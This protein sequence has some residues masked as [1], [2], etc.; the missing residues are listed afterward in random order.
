MRF[1]PGGGAKG[2]E[3]AQYRRQL[4]RFIECA[5]NTVA[6]GRVGDV[7]EPPFAHLHGVAAVLADDAFAIFVRA[8]V[9]LEYRR[10]KER[11]EKLVVPFVTRSHPKLVSEPKRVNGREPESTG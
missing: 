10:V 5:Q 6:R 7:Y 3:G 9:L 1:G 4:R 11:S 8:K 2:C